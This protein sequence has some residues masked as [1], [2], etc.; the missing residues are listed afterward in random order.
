MKQLF[1]LYALGNLNL[2]NRIV[3]APMT[4]SRALQNVP[5]ELMAQYYAQRATAGLIITEG[6][7]PSPDGLG[8]ARIPGIFSEDQVN[9][10]RKITS[11]VHSE[12]GKIF[13]Q[14]MHTGRVGHSLNLPA[15]A[16]LVAPSPVKLEATQMWVDN[17]GLKEIPVAEELT[18]KE[19]TN[20]IAEHIRAAENAIRAGFDGVEL[21]AANGY[22]IKQFLNPHTNRRTDQYGG[23]IA[24]R[25]R[26]LFEVTEGIIG[27]IGKEKTGVRISPFGEFNET[28]AY[29]EAA[30][31]YRVIANRLN[32][33][34]IA[35]LH[36][37]DQLA[38]GE[39]N[40]LVHALR[41]IFRRTVILS[42]GYTAVAAEKVLKDQVADLVSF[43]RPFIPNPDLV[44]RFKNNLPLNQ[45]KFDLFYSPGP[46]GYVD[47]PVFDEVQVV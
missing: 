24:N 34:K 42:G 41:G 46:E 5:N 47:Y 8:Y 12:G 10:W 36:I 44:A 27:A 22:L 7:S 31:T 3:M 37:T 15:G 17:E 11:A 29:Q 40:E 19:V 32:E 35:Y 13:L 38:K 14:L 4:R 20:A 16:R 26:F 6:T 33:L 1:S 9:G 39:P 28:P 30:E 45:P 18:T 2:S 43:A 25:T 23:S 21:H